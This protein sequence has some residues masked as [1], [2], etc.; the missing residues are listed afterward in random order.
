MKARFAQAWRLLGAQGDPDPEFS[1]L[2]RKYSDAR[3]HYHN[4]G[5]IDHCLR[6][7]DSARYL[8]KHPDLARFAI[9]YHDGIYDTSPTTKDNE[10]NSAIWAQS[11]CSQAGIPP[12]LSSVVATLILATKH[13]VIPEGEDCRLFMDIDLAI[14]GQRVELFDAYE[15]AVR[16]E[17]EGIPPDIYCSRRAK[18]LIGFNDR[19]PI[20][21]TEFFRNRYEGKAH[22]NLPTTGA[23]A[24]IVKYA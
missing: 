16:Q 12:D 8:F 14:F 2:D 23:A 5:H 18:I 6:E 4:W 11:V 9:F 20:Y 3:R 10:D 21:L 22:K 13:D 15:R 24:I 7:F 17:Y 19:R 1:R